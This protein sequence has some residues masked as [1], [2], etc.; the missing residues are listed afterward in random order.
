LERGAGGVDAP[1][2]RGEPPQ[3]AAEAPAR[4]AA[5]G[6]ED[7][8]GL[9]ALGPH[10][11][12]PESWVARVLHGRGAQV[13]RTASQIQSPTSSVVREP[14]RSGVVRRSAMERRTAASTRAASRA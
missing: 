9:V 2:R 1:V 5:A 12:L 3:A 6:E 11:S 13:S 10:G 7:D 4:R 8:I 14:P